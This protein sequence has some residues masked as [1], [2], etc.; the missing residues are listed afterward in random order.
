[1]AKTIHLGGPWVY[2]PVGHWRYLVLTVEQDVLVLLRRTESLTWATYTYEEC[3]THPKWLVDVASGEPLKM[4]WT[5][6]TDQEL[7]EFRARRQ[8][9]EQLQKEVPVK[10]KP[11]KPRVGKSLCECGC[12]GTTGG[13]RYLPGHDA[14]HKSALIR[15]V[16]ENQDMG[17]YAVLEE[18]GWLKFL[19]AKL[20]GAPV[21]VREE[22]TRKT[23]SPE[24]ISMMLQATDIVRAW[25]R[26]SRSDE[27]FILVT[28]DVAEAV[29]GGW[30]DLVF[31]DEL[32]AE[33]VDCPEA[34]RRA[35]EVLKN[36]DVD[37]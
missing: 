29:V 28:Y 33:G 3:A 2:N 12:K 9:E 5:P 23:V 30:F 26:S 21:V 16:L 36:E 19:E 15:A 35:A 27:G 18:K 13:G 4:T 32:R 20:K 24:A 34:G 11:S 31:Y 6:Y 7:N 25:G 17:A 14:K 8:Q 10:P 22:I 37:V 1:M